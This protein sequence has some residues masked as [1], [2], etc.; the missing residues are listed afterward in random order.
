MADDVD[1]RRLAHV[2]GAGLEGETEHGDPPSRQPP[3]QRGGDLGDEAP[4]LLR[5][6]L[7]RGLEEPEAVT[8]V[9]GGL[10]EGTDVLGKA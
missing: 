1:R 5:V 4:P 2:V 8:V 6:D 3:V 9:R 7:D 10:L